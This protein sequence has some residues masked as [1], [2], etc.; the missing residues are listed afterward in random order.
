MNATTTPPK[1]W[2]RVVSKAPGRVVV[3]IGVGTQEDTYEISPLASDYGLATVYRKMSGNKRVG[4]VYDVVCG[5]AGNVEGPDG[6]SCMAF[7][8]S[9]HCRHTEL[10]A[11][12]ISRGVVS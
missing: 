6:C 11:A 10:L 3:T 7:S 4:E 5:H 12:L 1:R 9:Q 8:K 2:Y